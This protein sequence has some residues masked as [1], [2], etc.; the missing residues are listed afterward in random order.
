MTAKSLENT[1]GIEEYFVNR[2]KSGEI[3]FEFTP[4][5]DQK[6][7]LDY[8]KG[9]MAISAVPGAGKTTILLALV[10]KLLQNG[11]KPENIFVLTYMDSAARNFKER[12]KKICPNLNAMP[13]ISTIHG[14]ALRIL[15][16]NSN[17]VKI[18]LETDFEVC[19]DDKRAQIL[20]RLLQNIIS[21]TPNLTAMTGRFPL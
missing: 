9:K 14:L 16:E 8:K 21:K 4:R 5:E 11:V 12:I 7:V 20:H 2:A 17:S 18:G 13:N 10:I 19:D 1:G 6:P 15:K 3:T